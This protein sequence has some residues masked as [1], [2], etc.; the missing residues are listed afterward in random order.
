MLNA[1]KVWYA[2]RQLAAAVEYEE[3]CRYSA[4]FMRTRVIPDLEAKLKSA[5]LSALCAKEF[6]GVKCK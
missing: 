4:E 1:L 5:E 2:R 3:E 6:R